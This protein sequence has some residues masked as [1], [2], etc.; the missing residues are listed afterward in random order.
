M[1][2]IMNISTKVCR[3]V[4][5]VEFILIF[6]L[7]ITTTTT[8]T[9]VSSVNAVNADHHANRWQLPAKSTALVTGSTKGIGYAIVSELGLSPFG[10]KIL[11]CARN[12]NELTDCINEWREKGCDVRGCVADVSTTKGRS[13]LMEALKVLINEEDCA[14]PGK[15]DILVNNVGTNIRRQSSIDYTEEDLEF[16]MK[17]N[18][19]SFFELT[20]LCHP[21]LVRDKMVGECYCQQ[22]S[23]VVNI[24][25]VAGVTCMK[26]GTPYAATKAAMNQLTGN[27]AC[28]WG[29]LGIRVN[30]VAPWYINTALAQQVLQ[31][32]EYKKTVLERTPCGRVGEPEEVAALVAFLCLPGAAY[33]T[34]QIISVDGGFTR[35]SFYDSFYP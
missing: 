29:P 1:I 6:S 26:S 33:I 19:K 12:E 10:C 32:E 27:W 23:S 5:L 22:T 13:T 28:E 14:T 7:F 3:I 35:N 17:T 15:L 9:V 8:T 30:C 24:G 34:G 2:E 16:I 31:N 20:K 25:S 4:F 18:F 21:Y 11:T